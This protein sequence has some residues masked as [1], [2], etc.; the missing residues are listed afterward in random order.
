MNRLISSSSSSR[1]PSEN[2]KRERSPV[3]QRRGFMRLGCLIGFSTETS[4]PGRTCRVA[5]AVIAGKLTCP[6]KAIAWLIG[7]PFRCGTHLNIAP[8]RRARKRKDRLSLARRPAF[9]APRLRPAVRIA[10]PQ[11][12][13]LRVTR[14][15]S[16]SG[17]GL[18][19]GTAAAHLTSQYH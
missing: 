14:K 8:N 10:N 12:R 16:P 11:F 19:L 15:G 9:C 7:P 5:R 1:N 4:F 2:R 13:R 17:R 18:T 3:D 6:L